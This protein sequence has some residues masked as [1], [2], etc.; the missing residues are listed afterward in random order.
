MQIEYMSGL[1]RM[2]WLAL[3]IVESLPR[4][5]L[6][7]VRNLQFCEILAY[8]TPVHRANFFLTDVSNAVK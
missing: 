4:S 6:I 2:R 7:P 1:V 3:M 8:L 5:C